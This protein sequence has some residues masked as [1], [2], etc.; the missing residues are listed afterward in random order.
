VA[1][2]SGIRVD[3]RDKGKFSGGA[4]LY[5][6]AIGW[7]YVTLMMALA[8]NNIVAGS[9]TFIF[10]GLAPCALLLWLFGFPRR[11]QARNR[12]KETAKPK[13][14][15]TATDGSPPSIAQSTDEEV[16]QHDGSNSRRN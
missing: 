12:A 8:E 10:Y 1:Y 9:M 3:G 16:N 11:R 15:A 4:I 6:V 14:Q 13:S 7:L 5:I 2:I